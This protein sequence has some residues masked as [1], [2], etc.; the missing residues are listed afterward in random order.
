MAFYKNND[1]HD[2]IIRRSASQIDSLKRYYLPH[3]YILEASF[4][5]EGKIKIEQILLKLIAGKWLR[6]DAALGMMVWAKDLDWPM[7]LNA[8]WCYDTQHNDTQLNDTQN[9]NT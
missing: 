6:E 5:F 3:S 4:L 9:N 1:C 2:T 7:K 8:K